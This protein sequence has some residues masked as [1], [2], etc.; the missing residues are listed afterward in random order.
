MYLARLGTCPRSPVLRHVKA[1]QTVRLNHSDK[2]EKGWKLSVHTHILRGVQILRHFE[3]AAYRFP[4]EGKCKAKGA[5][6]SV[7]PGLQMA[8]SRLFFCLDLPKGK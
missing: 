5:T 1:M 4:N 7:L 3:F 6:T 8:A 2:G